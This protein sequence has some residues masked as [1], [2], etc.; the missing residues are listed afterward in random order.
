M[1]KM[2]IP[3]YNLSRQY[4]ALQREFTEK[5]VQVAKSQCFIL[6]GELEALEDELSGYL[7]IKHVIGVASG[8]DALVI[9]M[10][11]LG[12]GDGDEVLTCANPFLACTSAVALTGAKPVL[13]DVGDDFNIDPDKIEPLITK[14]TRALLAIHLHGRPTK[15]H[16]LKQIAE[17]HNLILLEDCAQSVG[18]RVNGESVGQF[19]IAAGISFHPNKIL[20]CMGDGGAIVTNDPDLA[21]AAREFRNH[22]LDNGKCVRWGYNSRLSELGAGMLRVNL[23]HLNKWIQRRREIAARYRSELGNVLSCNNNDDDGENYCTYANYVAQHDDRDRLVSF[24]AERGIGTRV[25]YR[26]PIH[27]HP[28]AET[29]EWV[30]GSLEKTEQQADSIIALPIYQELTDDEVA[31]II[32]SVLD[33]EAVR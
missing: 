1:M 26:L 15:I 11:L 32:Q 21:K 9:S 3:F 13:V 30:P 4:E 12:I 5:F 25:L 17:K 31:Y 10:K 8:T 27:Q 22:G 7:G 33:F 2:S 18:A 28:I 29:L 20:S 23:P 6:G 19:G 16:R 14:S 24:L